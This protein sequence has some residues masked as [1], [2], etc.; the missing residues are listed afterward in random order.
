MTDR[1]FRAVLGT[2]LLACLYYDQTAIIA[3]II[4]FLVFE[5]LTNWRLPVL[6]ACARSS[7]GGTAA[8]LGRQP[9]QP[10]EAERA[11]RLVVASMLV[12]ALF[13]FPGPLWWLGWFIGFS[14]LGAGISGVCPL[15]TVLSYLGCK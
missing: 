3:T 15:L 10:F 7:T 6:V 5:G 14:M 4:G 13:L 8:C 11:L 2:V 12:V 9:L 1:Q